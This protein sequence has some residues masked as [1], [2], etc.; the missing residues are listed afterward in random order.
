VALLCLALGGTTL[1]S[2]MLAN[3][4]DRIPEI[5]LRRSLGAMP[6]DIAMLFVAEGCLVTA[7]ASAAGIAAAGA[8]AALGAGAFPAPVT[9]GGTAVL[10][11]AL[12]SVGLGAIFSWWPARMA[13][14][15]PPAEALRND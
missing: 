4:R 9:L 8:V 5:G 11:P 2:L 13:A 15:L 10:I 6:S 7:G 12:A 1:M 3:V 14:R